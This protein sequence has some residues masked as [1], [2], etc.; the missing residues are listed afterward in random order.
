MSARL[1]DA[2]DDDECEISLACV[3]LKN[4]K[5]KL[6]YKYE[7]KSIYKQDK[8]K[9]ETYVEQASDITHMIIID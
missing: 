2:R 4:K 3:A 8:K 6:I 1:R 7:M 9:H 5:S